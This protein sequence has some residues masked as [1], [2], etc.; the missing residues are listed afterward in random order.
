MRSQLDDL[1]DQAR[2]WR[3]KLALYR[4]KAYGPRSTTPARMR[5]LERASQG[6]DARLRRAEAAERD[7][8]AD[9]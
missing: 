7:P 3:D 9:D 8:A 1:R 6:A 2:Y 4:A 5:E